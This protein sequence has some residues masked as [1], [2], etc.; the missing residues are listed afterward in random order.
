M[1]R[2]LTFPILRRL[3]PLIPSKD[4]GMQCNDRDSAV[5]LS[6]PFKPRIAATQIF[7]QPKIAKE[8]KP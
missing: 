1:L 8:R 7:A 3:K 2:S 5:D 6:D 4:F